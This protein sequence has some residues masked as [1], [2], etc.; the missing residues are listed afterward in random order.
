MSQAQSQADVEATK[1]LIVQRSGLTPDELYKRLDTEKQS[2]DQA[3]K[4]QERTADGAG[5]RSRPASLT[6][7]GAEKNVNRAPSL[8]ILRL[9]TA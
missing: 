3:I 2:A 6:G 4:A 1:A 7:Y 5:R 8:P 9:K